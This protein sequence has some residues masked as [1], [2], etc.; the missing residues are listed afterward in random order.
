[1]KYFYLVVL[2]ILTG[3]MSLSGQSRL[4]G[5]RS[6]FTQYYLTPFLVHPGATGQNDYG[7]VVGIYRNTWSTFPG[8]PRSF[9]FGY[10]GAIGNRIG[11][12]LIGSSDDFAAFNTTKGTINLSYTVESANNKIGFGIAGEYINYGLTSRSLFSNLV[13]RSDIEITNRLDGYS[14]LDGGLGIY[15]IYD[16]KLSYG[17]TLPS[18]ISSRLSGDGDSGQDTSEIGFIASVGYR[19]DIPEK[20]ITFEPS[21]YAQKL[22]FTP[23]HVD[24]N[25]K[26]SFLNEQLTAAIS[27][28]AGAE[29]R[30]GFLVGTQVNNLG[31]HYGYNASTREFQQFNNG[32][33]ELSVNLRLQPYKK[34]VK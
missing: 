11:L 9:T 19:L 28:S 2:L 6:V 10:D 17:L 1:M 23:F 21:I 31:I 24:I 18:L 25:L 27:G 14:F 16:N 22:M 30:I 13:D 7:Q 12:G 20:D 3:T 4:F 5:E 34:V 8:S 32:T 26:A 15:G 29:N 33:H